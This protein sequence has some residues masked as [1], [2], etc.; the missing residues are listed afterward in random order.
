MRISDWSSGV[1]S[2]DLVG[3]VPGS[4]FRDPP[5]QSRGRLSRQ[6][7][8]RAHL[9]AGDAS[10]TTTQLTPEHAAI[11]ARIEAEIAAHIAAVRDVAARGKAAFLPLLKKHGITSVDIPDQKRRGEGKKWIV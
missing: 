2:S 4:G 10:M 6:R 9:F 11:Q 1:C 7:R 5:P 3:T 8:G